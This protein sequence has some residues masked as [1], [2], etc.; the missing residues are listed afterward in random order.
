MEEEY[1]LKNNTQTNIRDF[2]NVGDKTKM[3]KINDMAKAYEKP[4][5]KNIV[6]LHKIPVDIE[7]TTETH[8]KKETGEEFT[9]NIIEPFE[10]EKYRV[11][12]SVIAQLKKLLEAK[13]D[14]EFFKVTKTGEGLGTEYFVTDV[15]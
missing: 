5:T 2:F 14:I 1:L 3:A 15:E 13:P 6:E 7:V 8:T 4:Q 9:V 10:G 12:N 11:P